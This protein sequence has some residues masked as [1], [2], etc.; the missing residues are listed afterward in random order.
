LPGVDLAWLSLLA[1]FA[2][3]F[4]TTAEMIHRLAASPHAV[5]ERALH[6]ATRRPK[7]PISLSALP[8]GDTMRLVH[9]GYG[10]NAGELDLS[11]PLWVVLPEQ[12]RARC[13]GRDDPQRA[14]FQI[15][16]LPIRSQ[17]RA[18]IEITVQRKDLIRPCIG[19]VSAQATACGNDLP[20][21]PALRAVP[22]SWPAL[23]AAYERLSQDQQDLRLVLQHLWLSW[24]TGVPDA[25]AN[26]GEF[27]FTSVPFTGMGFTYDWSSESPDHIG[28]TEFVVRSGAKVIVG[29]ATSVAEFCRATD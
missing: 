21:A 10:L 1:G 19:G 13:V 11:R 15:L 16:G 3:A 22:D 9:F 8:D 23:A 12:V 6:E 25:R 4:V 2:A 20:P 5:Y 7:E 29:P 14:L 24:Q 26:R 28:I 18:M 17:R 27:P